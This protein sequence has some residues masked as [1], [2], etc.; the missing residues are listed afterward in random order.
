MRQAIRAAYG[1]QE[2]AYVIGIGSNRP[3]SRRLGPPAIAKAALVALDASPS[4]LIAHSP[5][6]ATPPLGPSARIYANA[7]ALVISVL[8]PLAMLDHLQAIERRFRRRRFRRWGPRTLDLDLLLWSGGS[9]RHRRLTIPHPALSQR[10]FVL[11][12]LRAIAPSWRLPASE[13]TIAHLTSR[14]AKPKPVDRR[15]RAL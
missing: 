7:A 2:H 1:A 8:P 10:A 11:I 12:P 4:R 9:L 15:S 13:L 3:L 6:V 14:I 5:I